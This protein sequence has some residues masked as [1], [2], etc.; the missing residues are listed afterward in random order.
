MPD[1]GAQLLPHAGRRNHSGRAVFRAETPLHVCCHP[2]ICRDI[3]CPPQPTARGG[4]EARR[5]WGGR[6]QKQARPAALEISVTLWAADATTAT[7]GRARGV[8]HEALG[9]PIRREECHRLAM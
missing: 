9:S 7:T 8:G 2:G 1:G 5:V 3:A 4:E 6:R